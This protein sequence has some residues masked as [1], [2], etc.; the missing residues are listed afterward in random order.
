MDW[1]NRKI[2]DCLFSDVRIRSDGTDMPLVIAEPRVCR[3][4]KIGT[5]ADPYKGKVEFEDYTT[6]GSIENVVF[7]NVSVTGEKGAFR[8]EIWVKG[9]SADESVRNV[10][11]ENVTR[12]GERVTA[13]SPDVLVEN[14]ENVTFR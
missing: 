1:M 2:T 8:G 7:R 11:F 12:F 4:F 13:K 3:C 6:G 5:G 10:V 14:A 9:R